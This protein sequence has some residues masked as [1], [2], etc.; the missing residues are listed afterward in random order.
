ML[1]GILKQKTN[2]L[3][4]IMLPPKKGDRKNTYLKKHKYR[5]KLKGLQRSNMQKFR[6]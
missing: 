5:P 2:C 4:L 1:L 3:L 6:K